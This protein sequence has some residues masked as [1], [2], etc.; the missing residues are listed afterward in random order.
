MSL[1]ILFF[2]FLFSLF[3]GW[4]IGNVLINGKISDFRPYSKKYYYS[5]L[6]QTF[7]LAMRLLVVTTI[8]LILVVLLSLISV[9]FV[10]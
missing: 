4:L 9:F 1:S 8:F 3:S 6:S 10:P 7:A 2:T 5:P